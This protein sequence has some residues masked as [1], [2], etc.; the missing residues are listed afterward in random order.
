MLMEVPV[1]DATDQIWMIE[2]NGEVNWLEQGTVG[3]WLMV[4]I[5]AKDGEKLHYHLAPVRR[6]WR[7]K[8]HVEVSMAH[9][10]PRIPERADHLAFYFHNTIHQDLAISGKA[11]IYAVAADHR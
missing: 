2:F 5:K 4:E 1:L 6:P 11:A 7:Y 8:D 10:L 3:L 9:I